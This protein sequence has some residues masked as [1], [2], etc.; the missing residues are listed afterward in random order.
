LSDTGVGTIL[1]MTPKTARHYGKRARTFMIAAGAA[2]R[3]ES[4]NVVGM[5][6]R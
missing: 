1:G 3:I 4:G 5:T 2:A 6:K